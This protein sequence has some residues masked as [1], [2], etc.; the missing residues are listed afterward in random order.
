MFPLENLKGK[1]A[2]FA[3]KLHEIKVRELP[4]VNDEFIKESTGAETLDAYKQEVKERLEKQNQDRA[5]REIED[6]IV[7]KI[8]ENATV[9]I[10]DA[11]VEN[12]VDRMVKETEYRLSYQG[13]KLDDYLKYAGQ[14][15]EEY[16]NG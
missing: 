13:L 10:P 4:E 6:E 16:R 2:V 5:N 14:T 9:E 12:Q 1:D 7:K 15:M 3:I 11:L 8:T